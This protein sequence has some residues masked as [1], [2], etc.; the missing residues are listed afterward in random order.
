MFGIQRVLP[1]YRAS[2]CLIITSADT[3]FS[4]TLAYGKGHNNSR[5]NTRQE[6]LMR[7]RNIGL[8]IQDVLN[9]QLVRQ[10]KLKRNSNNVI[11]RQRL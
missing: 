5:K 2:T 10:E 11:V 1:G 8:T 7:Y 3:V 9:E 6:D 4:K